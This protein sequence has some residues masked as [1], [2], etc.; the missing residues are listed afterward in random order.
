MSCQECYSDNPRITPLFNQ[1]HCLVNHLQ[2]I[3]SSCGRCIC[4]E[5]D[6]ETDAYRWSLPFSALETAKLYLRSAEVSSSGLCGIYEITGKDNKIYYKIFHTSGDLDKYLAKNKDK[7]CHNKKPSYISPK[8][9]ESS[10][11]VRRLN[12]EEV[13][14]YLKEQAKSKSLK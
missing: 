7:V 11:Q 9:V 3:C 1:E 5:R 4:I 6:T 2:Y 13:S 10:Q 14:L 8:Y 12:S